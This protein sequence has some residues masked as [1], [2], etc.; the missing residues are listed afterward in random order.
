APGSR[1]RQ[2]QRPRPCPCPALAA[3]REPANEPQQPGCDAGRPRDCAD[4]ARHPPP[5]GDWL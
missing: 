1:A 5:R 2:G 4:G 3:G